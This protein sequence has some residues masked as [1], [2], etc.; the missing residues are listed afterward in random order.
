MILR[1]C[2]LLPFTVAEMAFYVFFNFS[3]SILGPFLFGKNPKISQPAKNACF[4]ELANFSPQSDVFWLPVLTLANKTRDLIF[5][6][7]TN[8]FHHN[9][10]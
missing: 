9:V 1:I 10:N 2:A 5:R 3:A 4:V 8:A 7:I 6:M